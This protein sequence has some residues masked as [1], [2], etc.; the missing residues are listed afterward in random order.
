MADPRSKPVVHGDAGDDT[1]GKP[2]WVIIFAIILVVLLLLFVIMH[3]TS[4]GLRNHTAPGDHAVS[5]PLG[6]SHAQAGPLITAK[7]SGQV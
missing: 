3:L 6:G 5:G 4:G 1:R 7:P 2:R